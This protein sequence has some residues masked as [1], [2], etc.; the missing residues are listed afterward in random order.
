MCSKKSL[1]KLRVLNLNGCMVTDGGL[2]YLRG[3]FDL[4]ILYVQKTEVT[5]QGAAALKRYVP[6][7]AVFR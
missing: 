3:L 7:L 4:R 2:G 5:D 1:E 6:P